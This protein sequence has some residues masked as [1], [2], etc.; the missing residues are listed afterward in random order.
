MPKL[1][2]MYTLEVT[3]DQFI[4]ACSDV[5]LQELGYAA[6]RE[7]NRRE[8]ERY[9]CKPSPLNINDSLPYHD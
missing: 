8:R 7:I 3:V 2:K 1:D 6:D 4:R 9:K 5:E